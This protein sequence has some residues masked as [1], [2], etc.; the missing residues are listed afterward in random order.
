VTR[1]HHS[2][3]PSP[4]PCPPSHRF[5]R[6]G[7]KANVPQSEFRISELSGA[8]G[9][10]LDWA[11]VEGLGSEPEDRKGLGRMRARLKENVREHCLAQH[12]STGIETLR[13]ALFGPSHVCGGVG[14]FRPL[15]GRRGGCAPEGGEGLHHGRVVFE[16]QRLH[17]EGVGTRF[18]GFV[19]VANVLR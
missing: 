2:L 12:G 16:F 15:D 9:L 13:P 6:T 4:P 17:K 5:R 14:Y 1:R 10:R 7:R 19:D 11:M 18:V 3:A 8:G